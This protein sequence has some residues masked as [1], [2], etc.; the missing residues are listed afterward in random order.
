MKKPF[1]LQKALAGHPVVT[2]DGQRVNYLRHFPV[3]GESLVGVREGAGNLSIWEEDGR[4]LCT[5]P[6]PYDLFL[7]V[8]T[9][10]KWARMVMMGGTPYA[11]S[12]WDS[13]EE[14]EQCPITNG[15]RVLPAYEYT[16]EE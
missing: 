15:Y 10:K 1:D 3:S 9:V 14:A 13:K 5:G 11:F 6:H 16:V 2:R 12:M 8:K 4:H 7:E